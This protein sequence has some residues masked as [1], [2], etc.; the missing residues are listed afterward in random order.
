[1]DDPQSIG[2]SIWLGLSLWIWRCSW[3]SAEVLSLG[4]SLRCNSLEVDA[5]SV[6]GMFV[7]LIVCFW[8]CMLYE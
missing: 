7:G 8:S 1:M 5:R 2:R 4:V 3:T 6:L